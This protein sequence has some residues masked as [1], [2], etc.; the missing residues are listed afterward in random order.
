MNRVRR[1]TFLGLAAAAA[2]PLTAACTSESETDPTIPPTPGPTEST[3][4]QA[5]DA[6][7]RAQV[8]Q[9]E[10]DLVARYEATIA[11]HP[12]LASVLAPIT[13]QHRAHLAAVLD[14]SSEAPTT[15]PTPAV[16]A[17]PNAA[18][19]E[20]ISAERAAADAR[21]T[22]CGSAGSAELAR[23][24]ALIAASEASH[25]EALSNPST[26]TEGGAA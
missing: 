2:F 7:L 21:T 14:A 26:A 10:N 13:E 11:A 6:P 1:R 5:D 20:I 3:S 18:L 25:A 16:P 4:P 12:G 9:E 19:T 8:S 23:L 22:A 15:G 17:D 24:L